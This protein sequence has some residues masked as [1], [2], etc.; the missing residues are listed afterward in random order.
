MVI[1]SEAKVG[2]LAGHSLVSHQN[3]LRFQVPVV[4]SNRMAV[5]HGIQDLEE[6]ALGKRIIAN[7]LALLGDVGKQITFRAV[8]DDNVCAVRGVHDFYQR[9]NVG[10]GTGLVVKLDFPLLELPLPGL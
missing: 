2:K 1:G 5:L 3:V 8:F 10:V 6:G 9:D 7:I 4:D